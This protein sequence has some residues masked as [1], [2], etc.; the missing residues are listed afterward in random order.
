VTSPVVQTSP[1]AR[2][3]DL[4]GL[5]A[6]YIEVGQLGIFCDENLDYAQRLSRA[7][8]AVEFHLPNPDSSSD[9]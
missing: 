8:V 5:P 1:P 6:C 3:I 2:V 7:G 9:R 4:S